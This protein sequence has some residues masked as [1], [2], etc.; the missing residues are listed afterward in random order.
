MRK[1]TYVTKH[2]TLGLLLGVLAL[3]PSWA[4]SPDEETEKELINLQNEWATARIKGDVAFL[5][6]LYAKEFRITAMDGS[7]VDRARDIA[8]FASGEMKPQAINDE[9]MK[10]AVYGETAIVTGVED[11]KGTYKGNYG[12]FALRFTNVFIRR[13]GRWQMVTHHS[14]PVR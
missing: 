14:T 13:D 9:N 8:V 6:R 3:T 10:V 12:E 7:V 2:G 5:E 11:V 1:F 4:Q